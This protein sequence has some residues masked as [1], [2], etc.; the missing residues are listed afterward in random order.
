MARSYT[1]ASTSMKKLLFVYNADAGLVSGLLDMAHKI[2]SLRTY[3]CSLCGI[4]YGAASMRPEWKQF[5]H[6]LPVETRFLHRDEFQQE[7][8]KE[9]N[10]VLPA[11]FWQQDNRLTSV[12]TAAELAPLSLSEL[13]QR[14][15]QATQPA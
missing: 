10:Q 9:K 3:P 15:Q 13:M 1:H 11:V 12:L 8:L 6:S 5:L 14:L 2:L 4:T 7:F